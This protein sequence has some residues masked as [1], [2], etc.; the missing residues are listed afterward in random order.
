MK[1]GL[2]IAGPILSPGF[3]P[4]YFDK[5]GT[6]QKAWVDYDSSQNI[7]N[8]MNQASN[9]FD[10]VVLVTWKTSHSSNFIEMLRLTTKLEIIEL[11][12]N[13][14]LIDELTNRGT[15][16][17]HQIETMYAGVKKLGELGCDVIAKVR[18]THGINLKIL[19]DDVLHHTKRNRRSV[20]VSYMNLF[21]RDRLVDYH[22]IGNTDVIE[23]MCASYLSTPELFLGVHEDYYWKFANFLS[24]NS[25]LKKSYKISKGLSNYIRIISDWTQFFYPLNRKLLKD[26]FWRGVKVNSNLNFWIFWSHLFHAKNSRSLGIKTFG[27]IVVINLAQALIRPLIRPY[28][29][30]AYKF[31]RY[32]ATRKI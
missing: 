32:R 6:Y 13:A 28:S 30:F 7:L 17:Y 11:Y 8:L 21:E 27:N 16:K 2:I 3:T 29:F 15:S 4:Y 24:G 1:T 26:F 25:N 18:T 22:F 14:F 12:E 20:G 31:Y 5:D 10:H 19:F 23:S 9:L